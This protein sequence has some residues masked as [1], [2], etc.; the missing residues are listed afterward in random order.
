MN[1][2]NYNIYF[3]THTISGIII[4]A[5]LYVI[6]FAG[7]F[8]FFRNEIAAWQ[9][10]TSYKTYREDHKNVDHLLDS[11][12]GQTNLHGRDITFYM[13]REG[14]SAYVGLSAS[15]DSIL[16]KENLAKITPEQKAAKKNSRRRGGDDDSKNFTYNFANKKAGDYVQNYD[17]GEFL[18]RLHFLAQ[19]NQVPI[20]VGI[21]PFGYLI[22]G[23]TAFIFLFALITGLLLHWDKIVSNFFV[24]RPFSKWKTVWTDMHTALG[25]IGFPFQFIF[26]VTGTFLIINSVLALPLS[27]LLYD[28]DQQKMYQDIGVS[29][30]TDF[31]YT[32]K[33]LKKAIAI[34]P[35]LDLAKHKW[36][37]ADF[38]RI[39]IKNYADSNMH[40]VMELEPHFNKS[41]AGSG[42]LSVRAADNK[43]VAEKSP[44][45]DASYADGVRSII[46]RLHYG[47][48]GGYP[49]KMVYF[50]LGV[51]GC[52]VIISGILIWL[53]ARDKNNVIPRKRKFNF[54]AA[55]IFT[56]ICLTMLP[57]TALTFIAIKLSPAVN[58]D[59]IYRVYFYSWLLFSLYYI[60]R[61]SIRR[62]N[63]ETLLVGSILAF[64]IPLVNGFMTGNW[65][66]DTF[67]NGQRDIFVVDFLWLMIGI[68]GVI[69]YNKTK[70][71]F[72]TI[73]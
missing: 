30:A 70:K 37:E 36:P 6:F 32:Y 8:A 45:N 29:A 17:M 3:N 40:V 16:N 35:F 20:R 7:S 44:V 68:I 42:L 58:Q 27:K 31:P 60:I 24:F 64:F 51:M 61:R 49:L 5:I 33:P 38:Q 39:T 66:W 65:I 18:F 11:L 52:L 26:A 14:T 15:N 71:F 9:N 21:A 50:I 43:V 13:H 25:V 23:I 59:F 73:R 57:V 48:Y 2:R 46:Y 72:E 62:T 54:W 28:G 56:A 55:N 34:A 12:K 63:R 41:F 53:V 1:N 4:C 69:A 22:A 47:D 67:R 19:L 10:N